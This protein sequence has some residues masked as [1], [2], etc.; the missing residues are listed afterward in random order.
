MRHRRL[1][2]AERLRQVTDARF[3]LPGNHR[4]EAKPR[5]GRD[6]FESTRERVGVVGADRIPA[7]GRAVGCDVGEGEGVG[8][9]HANIIARQLT[10]IDMDQY[11]ISTM[12]NVKPRSSDSYDVPHID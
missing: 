3:I 1:A 8:E 6:R 7:Q 12:I 5:R 10:T 11:S 2:Q 4:N 9:R